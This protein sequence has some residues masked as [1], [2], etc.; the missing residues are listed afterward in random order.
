[1]IRK[2]KKTQPAAVLS[3]SAHVQSLSPVVD[4]YPPEIAALETF[5]VR[6]WD[7]TQAAAGVSPEEIARFR[8]GHVS[9]VK[10]MCDQMRSEYLARAQS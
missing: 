1:M 6:G 4:D 5:L 2:P 9:H 8:P 7:E 10:A 3:N